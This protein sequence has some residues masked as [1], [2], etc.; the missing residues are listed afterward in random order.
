MARAGDA[1]KKACKNRIFASPV[2]GEVQL[3]AEEP[4]RVWIFASP[5][6]GEAGRQAG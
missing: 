6:P 5:A 3:A 2:P 1:K 4:D